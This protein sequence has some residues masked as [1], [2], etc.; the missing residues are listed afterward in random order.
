MNMFFDCF[1]AHASGADADRF[2]ASVV[3]QSPFQQWAPGDPIP[4]HAVRLLIGVRPSSGYD[5]R[6]LDVIVEA[7]ACGP[8]A[9]PTV[10]LFD[11]ASCPR[12]D[13]CRRYIPALPAIVDTPAAGIWF[14][15]QLTWFGQGPAA[16]DQIARM[17]GSTS[18][19]II[20]YVRRH[21]QPRTSPQGA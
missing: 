20:D 18:Q 5:M 12:P 17:F 11:V 7:M 13:D 1:A 3:E 9:L 15:G 16:R 10:D 21:T 19:Q 6:L 8:S 4:R 14:G 2:F